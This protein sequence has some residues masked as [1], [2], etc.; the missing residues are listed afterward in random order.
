MNALTKTETKGGGHRQRL[1]DRFRR[2]GFQGFQDYEVIEYLLTFA[3]PRKDTKP[4]AKALIERFGNL[5]AVMDATPEAFET[6]DGIGPAAGGLLSAIRETARRYVR[7]SF[8]GKEIIDTP[9]A[10]IAYAK[11]M[12][13]GLKNESFHVICLSA[14][15]KVLGGKT[16]SEGSVIQAAV[17]P[18]QIVE[19]ALSCGASGFILVHNHPSG[20]PAPSD[21]DIDMTRKLAST[22]RGLDLI[23]HD[24]VVIGRAGYFSMR[25]NGLIAAKLSNKVNF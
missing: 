19:T 12:L 16:I 20:D 4:L 24:H 17:Y 14:K 2:D 5:P 15:N 23:L 1:R 13:A 25:E 10:L 22:A 7:D 9:E 8:V 11:T 6:V 18:R 3:I 21:A